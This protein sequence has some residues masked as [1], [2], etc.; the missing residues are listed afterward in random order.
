VSEELEQCY[1]AAMRI[2]SYRFNS[3]A[4]LRRKLTSKRKFEPATIDATLVRLREENWLDDERFAGAFVRSRTSKRL[5]RNRIAR[6]LRATGVSDDDAQSAI[7]TNV[8]REQQE[9]SL[10]ELRDKRVRALVRRHGP[11]FLATSE[12][13]NKLTVYLLKQGYDAAL[14]YE[15]VKEIRVAQH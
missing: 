1:V 11:E 2:L 10:R 15:A 5:G 4:E 3:E 12:G 8:D 7:A 14:V 9:T 6:E 13:R